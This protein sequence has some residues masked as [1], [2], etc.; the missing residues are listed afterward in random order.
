MLV[1]A[2]YA[3][4]KYIRLFCCN[5]RTTGRIISTRTTHGTGHKSMSAKYEYYVDGV[6]YVAT[7]G[8]TTFGHFSGRTE[9]TVRYHP[10]KPEVSFINRS[11][12]YFNCALGTV[13]FL[14]GIGA[15][16]VGMLLSHIMYS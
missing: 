3:L 6:R 1:G 16:V 10:K 5:G 13:F 4:P 11:G 2:L 9:Y 7:T 15:F 12:I 8:R 14:A